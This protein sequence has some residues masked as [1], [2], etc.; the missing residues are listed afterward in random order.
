MSI[1]HPNQ[2]MLIEEFSGTMA[3]ISSFENKFAA[4][5]VIQLLNL[6]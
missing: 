3:P 2:T 4:L 1:T 6:N 5:E